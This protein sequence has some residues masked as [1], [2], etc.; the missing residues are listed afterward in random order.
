[1]TGARPLFHIAEAAVWQAAGQEYVPPAYAA[2]G[3]IHLSCRDQLAGVGER[4][5]RGVP[6]LVLL[7][8][9]YE[10]VAERLRWEPSPATGEDFPHLYGPL[11]RDAVVSVRPYPC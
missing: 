7:E 3:F 10:T 8:I 11:P 4:Y 6:G 2:E 9:R 1:V 5:Y